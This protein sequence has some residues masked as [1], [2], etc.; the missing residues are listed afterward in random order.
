MQKGRRKLNHAGMTLMELV[1]V[2]LILGILSAGT[3]T[4]VAYISRMNTTTITEKLASLLE[5]TRMYTISAE[6][7]NDAD[8]KVTLV[9]TKEDNTYY[10]KLM[11]GSVEMDKVM[12]GSGSLGLSLTRPGDADVQVADGASVTL[13][14][15]KANGAFVDTMPYSSIVISGTKTQTI[16]LVKTTGRSYIN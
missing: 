16:Y 8:G 6:D 10:G 4:G 13:S 2:I 9:L 7:P 15:Q 12:L 14:Y 1:V 11:Q 5:R 3:V